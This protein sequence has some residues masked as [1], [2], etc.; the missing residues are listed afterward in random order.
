LFGYTLIASILFHPFWAA[1]PA[2]IKSDLNDFMKNLAIM[3]GM[4]YIMA[5][6]PGPLSL[7]ADDGADADTN[8]RARKKR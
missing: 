2:L 1:E 6:G 3:G 4:L 8:A 5:F 7:G